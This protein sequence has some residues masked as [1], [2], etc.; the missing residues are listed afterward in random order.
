MDH[1]V[2]RAAEHQPGLIV[3]PILAGSLL[4]LA[5]RAADPA[6]ITAQWHS[7]AG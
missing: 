6:L 3:D 1:L 7:L 4:V 2:R 5:A